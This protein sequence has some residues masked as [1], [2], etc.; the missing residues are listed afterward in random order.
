[1]VAATVAIVAVAA[2][3]LY[4]LNIKICKLTI[5]FVHFLHSVLCASFTRSL[6]YAEE[7][8]KRRKIKLKMCGGIA[9]L[10]RDVRICVMRII[11]TFLRII[12][13]CA[14]CVKLALCITH[15]FYIGKVDLCTC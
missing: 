5:D 4:L 1:M 8:E 7:T 13:Y 9:E 11:R 2:A 6:I 3:G 10:T 15:I 14:L 12:M